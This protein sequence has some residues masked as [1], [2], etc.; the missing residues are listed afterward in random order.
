MTA[1]LSLSSPGDARDRAAALG[2]LAG[3]FIMK[4][5]MIG[6]L[7]SQTPPFPPA[8][9]APTFAASLGLSA[10]CAALISARSRWFAAAAVPVIAESLLSYGPHKLYPGESALFAQTAAVYP[11]IAAG[12]ALIAVLAVTS[13]RLW[14][15]FGTD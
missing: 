8:V 12:S 1:T 11:A 2:A 15:R 3:L 4:T 5:A 10:L 14:R 13:V 7:Y 9:F 6:A